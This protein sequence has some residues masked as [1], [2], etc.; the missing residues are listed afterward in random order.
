MTV[1]PNQKVITV[2]KDE[3]NENFLQVNNTNWQIACSYL[4]YS[5]F[6]L[7]LYFASNKN[8]YT[9]ALSY[10]AIA[11]SIPMSRKT[12]DNAI[13]ELKLCGYLSQVDGNQWLFSDKA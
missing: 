1:Y 4:T 2:V 13:K 6:K 7:Y 5:A 11:K 8:G 9:F 3:C 12:Y 10:E